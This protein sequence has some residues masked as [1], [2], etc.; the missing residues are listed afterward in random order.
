MPVRISALDLARYRGAAE[1]MRGRL[2][3]V[4]KQAEGVIETGVRS[5]VVGGTAFGL[6]LANGRY[7]GVKVAG[8]PVDLGLAIVSHMAGFA[9][10]GGTQNKHLH[11]VGDGALAAYL[12]TTGRGVG[13]KMAANSEG[14]KAVKDRVAGELAAAGLGGQRLTSEQL[15]N[16]ARAPKGAPAAAAT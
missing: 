14:A 8:V 12:A 16:L 6:G 13:I 1:K 5:V 2:Q 15:D 3:S 4:R 9:G 10:L 7:G 11:S